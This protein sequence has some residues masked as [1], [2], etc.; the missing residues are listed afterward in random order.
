MEQFSQ[1]MLQLGGE[2]YKE[3]LYILPYL[4][5]GVLCEAIIRTFKWHVK[6]RKALTHYGM[7]AIP[8]ATA[9]GLFSPLCAC[10][11]LPLVISLLV[12][13]L[14]LAP[15]MALLV[16]APIMSPTGYTMISGMLGISWATAILVCAAIL[17]LVAG[18]VTHLLRPW[19]FTEDAIFRKQLPAG[20][21]HDPDYPVESLR[22][23]C[24]QQLSH[25]VD[26]CTHNKFLVFLARFWEGL[27]KIGKFA[28]F[29]LL[30]E[31]VAMMFIPSE[32][33]TGLLESDSLA[34][35]LTLSLST[36]FL[37]MPQVTAASMLF[38]FYL[39]EPGQVI[40]LAKGAGIILLIG[41]PVTALPVMGVFITMFKPR[42]L[43][44]YLAIC[45]AGP[46]ALALILRALP[47]TL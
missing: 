10:A 8:V 17:G 12:A 26:R 42:V 18:Y 16:T 43:A 1:T 20:D 14:P 47:I 9:L 15:A 4:L 33:V 39:P 32:W 6:I 46:L 44:L 45:V 11:T 37:H 22:C 24:G 2:I 34:S 41:A 40:P 23:E 28:L 13:G 19:G 35:L 21:F 5:I 36:V 7:L 29:G 27:L 3:F 30:I 31:V 25:R 38:G